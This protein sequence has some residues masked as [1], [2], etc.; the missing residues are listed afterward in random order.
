MKPLDETDDTAAAAEP[1]PA[2]TSATAKIAELE[3]RCADLNARW[4]RSQADFQNARRRAQ[5]E[6]EGALQRT[7]QPLLDELF[8]VADYLDLALAAPVTTPEGKNLA[9]GVQLTRAKLVQALEL[10]DVRLIPTTGAF[11][12]AQHEAAEGR[13]SREHD[14]GTILATVRPG[15]TW[16]GRILRPARVVVAEAPSTE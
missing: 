6:L 1:P 13:P 4:L 15:Y 16:Q 12:P 7:L 8:L 14:P 3:A 9:A 2:E 10:A 11:D 5:Q